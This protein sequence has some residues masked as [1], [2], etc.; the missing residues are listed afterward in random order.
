MI[1]QFQKS[2][3]ISSGLQIPWNS[4]RKL[5]QYSLHPTTPQYL[6]Y[7]D[8][9]IPDESDG[10]QSILPFSIQSNEQFRENSREQPVVSDCW[11]SVGQR[12]AQVDRIFHKSVRKTKLK[13]PFNTT[14]TWRTL[15]PLCASITLI[16]SPMQQNTRL[17]LT[18]R[19]LKI[20]SGSPKDW[21][22]IY[23]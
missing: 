7:D 4:Y 5:R 11:C 12:P 18:I 10:S 13:L 1:V 20:F 9:S 15:L 22:M 17:S 6:M 19:L 8:W 14:L 3:S 21:R 2:L 23:S 16:R